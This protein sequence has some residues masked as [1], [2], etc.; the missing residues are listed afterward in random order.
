[1][2]AVY[3]TTTYSLLLNPAMWN[4]KRVISCADAAAHIC[5]FQKSS[6]PKQPVKKKGNGE[7][8]GSYFLQMVTISYIVFTI[9]RHQSNEREVWFQ[10]D[11]VICILYSISLFKAK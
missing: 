4:L 6:S 9:F 3:I 2:Q 7:S 10:I 8:F 5:Q 1:M 11:S